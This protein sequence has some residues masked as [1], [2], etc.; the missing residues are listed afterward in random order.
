MGKKKEQMEG[1][2]GKIQEKGKEKNGEAKALNR[3]HKTVV[4]ILHYLS[5]GCN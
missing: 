5:V 4:F 3:E 2:G 1:N